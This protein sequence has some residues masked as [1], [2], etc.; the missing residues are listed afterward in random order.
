MSRNL[1]L[2]VQGQ[3]D[4][5]VALVGNAGTPAPTG[6]A[7][8]P[9]Y[10]NPA[11]NVYQLA[12]AQSLAS[13]ATTTPVTGIIGGS[14]IWNTV[15]T[16]SGGSQVILQSLGSDGATWQNV[17]TMSAS[18]SAGVVIGNNASVRL[19]GAVATTTA[20]SSSLS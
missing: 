9:I 3:V 13:A 19:L 7:A 5:T 2:G 14:Y 16:Y 6:S 4:F 18:G 10:F 11:Q 17:A 1:P 15:G 20:L 8:D 12:T